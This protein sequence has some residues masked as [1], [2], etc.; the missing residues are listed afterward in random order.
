MLPIF[1]QKNSGY[2]VGGHAALFSPPQNFFW[3]YAI[4]FLE[5]AMRKGGEML[6]IF[7]QNFGDTM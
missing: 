4:W 3:G 7:S 2:N 5:I 6:P 1:F